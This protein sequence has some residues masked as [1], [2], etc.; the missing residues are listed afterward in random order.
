MLP[1]RAC[2]THAYSC[3][4]H[5]GRDPRS[6]NQSEGVSWYR[7]NH[8][9]CALCIYLSEDLLHL[10]GT[11]LHFLFLH[12]TYLYNAS[13]IQLYPQA[14]FRDDGNSRSPPYFGS[15]A[16]RQRRYRR[17]THYRGTFRSSNSENNPLPNSAICCVD[18][19]CIRPRII[20]LL[21]PNFLFRP[22]EPGTDLPLEKPQLFLF[23][24]IHS[25]ARGDHRAWS[26]PAHVL[27]EI[28]RISVCPHL[29]DPIIGGSQG[30][31]WRR[32]VSTTPSSA[33]R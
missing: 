24:G 11:T 21:L 19:A 4:L 26:K 15:S 8:C 12:F 10:R 27:Y 25:L 13:T 3:A 22:F 20:E 32:E 9:G 1:R 23:Q 28:D 2:Q 33:S 6:G 30:R 5:T 17:K 29:A 18:A 14:R 16:F 7:R 31:R